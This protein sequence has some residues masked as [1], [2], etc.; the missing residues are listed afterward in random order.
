MGNA[1]AVGETF[2]IT[3]DESLTWNQIY[4]ALAEALGVELHTCHVPSDLLAASTVYDMTGNLLGDKANTVVFDN[5]KLKQVVPDF[6]ARIPYRDGVKMALEYIL[7][8]EECQ[9]LDPVFD[10]WC[11]K[12]VRIMS[13]AKDAIKLI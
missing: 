5:S 11:D 8:H 13:D 7:Q 6:E 9:R 12:V 1:R 4:E 3:S 10:A 2:H